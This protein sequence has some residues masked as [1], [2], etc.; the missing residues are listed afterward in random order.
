MVKR[1]SATRGYY[2]GAGPTM[3]PEPVHQRFAERK[4]DL[5]HDAFKLYEVSHRDPLICREIDGMLTKFRSL[6]AVPANYEVLRCVGGARHLYDMLP[7]NVPQSLSMAVL[8]TGLWSAL[9][10]ETISMLRACASMPVSV[11]G[12]DGCA[13]GNADCLANA[14]LCCVTNETADGIS[15][16]EHLLP[17]AAYTVADLTSDLGFRQIDLSRYDCAFASST[18]IW[19][20]W[21]DNRCH[22]TKLFTT[23]TL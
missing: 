19:G 13:P 14:V 18:S 20:F 16:P 1:C 17:R 8:N 3:L 23:A 9:W 5:G 7:L 12:K 2:F 4:I 21:D 15:L 10:A 6:C 22:L 11:F